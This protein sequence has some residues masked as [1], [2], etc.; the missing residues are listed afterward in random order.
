[1]GSIKDSKLKFSREKEQCYDQVDVTLHQEIEDSIIEFPVYQ[2]SKLNPKQ[3]FNDSTST[4]N[5]F[6]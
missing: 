4:S 2:V 5:I 1:M 3:S 6:L